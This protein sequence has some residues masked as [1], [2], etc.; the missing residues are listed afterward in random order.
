MRAAGRGKGSQRQ[1]PATPS[2]STPAIAPLGPIPGDDAQGQRRLRKGEG[3]AL[4]VGSPTFDFEPLLFVVVV[5]VVLLH[6]F[7]ASLLLLLFFFSSPSLALS[8]IVLSLS[9]SLSHHPPRRPRVHAPAAAPRTVAW[10]WALP[11]D[12]ARR[13][14]R[15]GLAAKKN[16]AVPMCGLRGGKPGAR[17]A[18]SVPQLVAALAHP[19]HPSLVSQLRLPRGLCQSASAGAPWWCVRAW[20]ER[21]RARMWAPSP[22]SL[23][24]PRPLPPPPPPPRRASRGLSPLPSTLSL[25]PLPLPRLTRRVCPPPPPPRG[26]E[27]DAPSLQLAC[28]RLRRLHMPP[29]RR[30]AP[31]RA[32]LFFPSSFFSGLPG[33]DRRRPLAAAPVA[34][35]RCTDGTRP[36]ALPRLASPRLTSP[37]PRP[38]PRRLAGR[39]HTRLRVAASCRGLDRRRR[40]GARLECLPLARGR[41]AHRTQ[42]TTATVRTLPV[43]AVRQTADGQHVSSSCME[44]HAW[45]TTVPVP[46]AHARA[47][48]RAN[49]PR[50]P[51]ICLSAHP[52]GC[53]STTTGPDQT[54]QGQKADAP[55]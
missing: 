15:G 12:V 48:V 22:A 27:M 18:E 25:F 42:L 3:A 13:P 34:R 51:S 37:R 30:C 45:C 28:Y 24:R 23:P 2:S 55:L 21:A 6:P 1:V 40:A 17:S 9:L 38:G 11:M 39:T 43:A 5:V 44:V 19:P 50:P 31:T 7:V 26:V 41:P 16:D 29:R 54:T 53:P 49:S 36:F 4:L 35:R 32:R 10:D 20:C 14:D 8:P 52:S 46:D 47:C 33:P